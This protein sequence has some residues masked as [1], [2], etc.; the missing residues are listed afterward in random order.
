MIYVGCAG[1]AI[2]REFRDLFSDEGTHLQRYSTLFNCVEINSCF[3]K[4]HKRSTYEKW[5]A[6][7]P[8]N[9]RFSTKLLRTITHEHYLTNVR[10]LLTKYL[11]EVQGLG[12]SL[13]VI[14]VQLP[15]KAAF[16]PHVANDFFEF[17]RSIYQ[18]PIACEPRHLSWFTPHVLD[19]LKQLQVTVVAA[20]PAINPDGLSI[21]GDLNTVYFRLHGSPKIYESD[22]DDLNIVHVKNQLKYFQE[23]FSKDVWCIFDNTAL[24]HATENAHSLTQYL[25]TSDLGQPHLNQ[26]DAL[27]TGAA[28]H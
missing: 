13:G 4:S 10:D 15:P 11:E 28:F 23:Q 2:R 26:S 16:K 18:G 24:G 8:P 9:F 1:W 14:L 6:S 27:I 22:Y 20:D 12:S 17:F 3:Y 7:V 19:F 21:A 5:A 25:R